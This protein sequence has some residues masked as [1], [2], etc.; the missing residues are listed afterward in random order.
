MPNT[1]KLDIISI[2]YIATAINSNLAKIWNL[3][4]FLLVG[5]VL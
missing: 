4:R 1:I 2:S 3:L 5:Q